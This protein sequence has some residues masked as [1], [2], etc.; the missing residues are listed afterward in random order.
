[1]SWMLLLATKSC[2]MSAAQAWGLYW[3]RCGVE[4]PKKPSDPMVMRWFGV[5]VANVLR[6]LLQPLL[7]VGKAV[8]VARVG[9][10]YKKQKPCT[11]NTTGG[12]TNTMQQKR[13]IAR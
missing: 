11:T 10:P 1:M 12:T 13:D 9:Q 5:Q 6:H 8:A 4:S 3:S 7:H 2:P